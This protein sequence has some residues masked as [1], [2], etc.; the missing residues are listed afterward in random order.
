M[1]YPTRFMQEIGTRAWLR[2]Y[3]DKFCAGL[4]YHNAQIH[5]ADS[6]E[7]ADW[8]LG[9]RSEDYADDRWPIR[10]DHCAA[11]VPA[12]LVGQRPGVDGVPYRQVFRRRLY[13]AQDGT[14][15]IRHEFQIGDMYWADWYSCSDR[16][17]PGACIHG[18][19][20]CDGRH[21]IVQIP[22]GDVAR[23]IRGDFDAGAP[24]SFPWDVD[25]RA[26]NCTLRD[27]TT[28]RCWVRHGDPERGTVHVDKACP[29]HL[30]DHTCNAGA[31]SIQGPNWHGFLHGGVLV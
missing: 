17:V 18:W 23:T 9:G 10:C 12:L 4:G 16:P 25:G 15:A 22:D 3:W 1:T 2:V 13:E 27:D 7:L 14:R 11:E 20:N 30:S 26:S 19:T 6:G 21:L 24:R 28:H 31:G 8:K 5:L 29:G